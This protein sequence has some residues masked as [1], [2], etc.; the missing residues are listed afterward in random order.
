MDKILISNDDGILADGVIASINALDSLGE[1]KVVCPEYENSGA[2]RSLSAH[3][4]LKIIEH[5]LKNGTIGYGVTGT[6]VD[7]VKLGIHKISNEKPDLLVAGINR[8]MN[9][10][11]GEI[12]GSGTV[13]AAIEGSYNGIPSIAASLVIDPKNIEF[14]PEGL[15]FIKPLNYDLASEI[16]NKLAKKVLDN[17]LPVGVDLLNLNVPSNPK[18]KRIKITRLG[19]KMLDTKVI[20]TEEDGEKK[21][22]IS[23]YLS[24][25]YEKGTDGYCI[26]KENQISLSPL[27]YDISGNIKNLEDW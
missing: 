7:S 9:I 26:F 3:K 5:R 25:D 11:K 6:P 15:K 19:N 1:L 21:Y 27:N 10:C 2:G 4:P 8:G 23:P 24:T 18:N 12:L 16:L 22:I 17:G 14:T 20:E 13:G